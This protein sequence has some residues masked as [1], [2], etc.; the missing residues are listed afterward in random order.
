MCAGQMSSLA[1]LVTFAMRATCRLGFAGA[2]GRSEVARREAYR[3]R[4]PYRQALRECGRLACRS[5]FRD[6]RIL[7]GGM[8]RWN[9]ARL[10]VAHRSSASMTFAQA[11]VLHACRLCR[12][13]ITVLE[14][15]SVH[16]SSDMCMTRLERDVMPEEL[17]PMPPILS[18][19]HYDAESVF[20]PDSILREA[21]RQKGLTMLPCLPS[22]SSTLT[23]TSCATS[24]ES[25]A[26]IGMLSGPAITPASSDN[27]GD[28]EL[29][30]VPC[31]V[32]ASF[33]VLSPSSCSPAD[34]SCS[35]ASHL[36]ASSS[37]WVSRRISC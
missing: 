16:R 37:N 21:R 36:R 13:R 6:V 11:L 9:E 10:P 33:A 3:S 28:L 15:L 25:V 18:N 29:G 24:N 27:E 35:L 2:T 31:A 22:A 20:T 26:P 23:A 5:W 12:R 14:V 34:A 17:R 7:R 32:G 1:L 4:L 8:V 30:I 19:K